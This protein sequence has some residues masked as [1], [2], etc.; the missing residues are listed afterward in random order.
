MSRPSQSFLQRMSRGQAKE[1]MTTCRAFPSLSDDKI[2]NM[3]SAFILMADGARGDLDAI[4]DLA[5]ILYLAAFQHGIDHIA[6]ILAD[7]GMDYDMIQ[8][9]ALNT[10]SDAQ[11]LDEDVWSWLDE[12]DW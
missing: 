10:T 7:A 8:H 12:L 1:L 5:S 9:M 4:L 6:E 2:N 3:I 11:D